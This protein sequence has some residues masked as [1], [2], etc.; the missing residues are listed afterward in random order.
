MSE[1][2]L[3]L[4]IV[5]KPREMVIYLQYLKKTNGIR[6]GFVH[7]LNYTINISYL[8]PR[9]SWF[10]QDYPLY[11]NGPS[12]TVEKWRKYWIVI[13]PDNGV[14][15]WPA[16]VISPNGAVDEGYQTFAGDEIIFWNDETARESSLFISPRIIE[17]WNVIKD[18]KRSSA[19]GASA[20]S[21][22]FKTLVVKDK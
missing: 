19:S 13:G 2:A 3:R 22:M 4:T 5:I 9:M 11:T 10:S 15:Q 14:G 17:V 16:L 1:N 18:L 12:L 6:N 21:A 8:C 7:K 20:M